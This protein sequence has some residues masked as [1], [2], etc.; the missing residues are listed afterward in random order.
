MKILAIS[1]NMKQTA[2]IMRISFMTKR[3][4][5]ESNI[6]SIFLMSIIGPVI[7]KAR[8]DAPLNCNMKVLAINASASEQSESTNARSIM[9]RIDEKRVPPTLKRI[10][11]GIKACIQDAIIAPKIK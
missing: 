8:T 1:A 11:L 2:R 10:S 7:R 4:L 3:F 6:I 5:K 9:I